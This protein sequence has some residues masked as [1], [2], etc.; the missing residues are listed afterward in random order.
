MI[1]NK[2]MIDISI[3]QKIKFMNMRRHAKTCL[4]KFHEKSR[5]TM[6]CKQM[7]LLYLKEEKN[8]NTTIAH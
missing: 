1:D 2:N 7:M 8:E 4:I 6:Y 5:L 3:D